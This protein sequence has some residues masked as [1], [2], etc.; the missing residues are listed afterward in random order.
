MVGRIVH[1]PC[2]KC[3]QEELEAG[4]LPSLKSYEILTPDTGIALFECNQHHHNA[5]L[6][7]EQTFEILLE[8]AI[9]NLVDKYYREAIFNFAA[10]QERCFEFFC[11]LI[12]FEKQISADNFSQCW[13]IYKNSS[14]R[15]L[16]AFYFLYLMRFNVPFE[17]NQ[18]KSELRNNVIH[19]GEIA[20]KDNAFEYGIYI[21]NNIYNIIEAITENISPKILN[22]FI[23][24]KNTEKSSKIN[25]KYYISTLSASILSWQV[26]T[27]KELEQEKLLQQYS[28][29]HPQEYAHK[30][31]EA[32]KLGKKILNIDYNGNLIIVDAPDP[33]LKK[34]DGHYVGRKSLDELIENVTQ[35]KNHYTLTKSGNVECASVIDCTNI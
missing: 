3:H 16:G 19:K 6:I 12:S 8:L 22:E 30:V 10:A 17:Y 25:G 15:Q 4:R 9:E 34:I 32:N 21:L 29:L 11:E 28:K 24:I 14:E 5:V 1:V 33:N 7:Q 35:I 26:A 23:S 20:T 13:K 2:L 18:K 31:A 27:P